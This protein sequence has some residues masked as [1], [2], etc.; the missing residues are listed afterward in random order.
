MRALVE[1]GLRAVKFPPLFQDV[2]D[3]PR[4][5]P[6]LEYHWYWRLG[7][8]M[9]IRVFLKTIFLAYNLRLWI[10]GATR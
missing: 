9:R 4:N 2:R 3:Y 8:N 7:C 5:G 6:V 1:I 10:Y